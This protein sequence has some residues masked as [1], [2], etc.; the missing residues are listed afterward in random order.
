MIRTV[1]VPHDGEGTFAL[2]VAVRVDEDDLDCPRARA[3]ILAT[4]EARAREALDTLAV[5]DDLPIGDPT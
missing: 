5:R 1:H 2:V 4:V 3:R